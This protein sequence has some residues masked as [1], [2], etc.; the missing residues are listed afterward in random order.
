MLEEKKKGGIENV[1][2][3]VEASVTESRNMS[4]KKPVSNGLME[5]IKVK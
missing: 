2:E 4:F 1:G 5:E 3:E